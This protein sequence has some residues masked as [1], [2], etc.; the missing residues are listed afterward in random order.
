MHPPLG[1]TPSC[2][3]N[4][5]KISRNSSS[6]SN[7]IASATAT[8]IFLGTSAILA[9]DFDNTR[10]PGYYQP[11]GEWIWVSKSMIKQLF[12]VAATADDV[13]AAAASRGVNG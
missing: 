10:V 2:N 8:R 3:N 11:T 1:S 9:I 12:A 6:S 13:A 7:N 4:S 5:S